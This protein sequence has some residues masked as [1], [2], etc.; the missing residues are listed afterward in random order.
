MH[1]E[2]PAL[3][4]VGL[5]RAAQ[6]DR[7]VGLAPSYLMATHWLSTVGRDG[8]EPRAIHFTVNNI[9]ALRL[10]PGHRAH[11]LGIDEVALEVRHLGVAQHLDQLGVVLPDGDPLALDC[12]TRRARAA[13]D[14]LHGQQHLG[15]PGRDR[16][17]LLGIDEVALEV[18]H[19]GVAQH[20]DQ[21]GV[22][23]GDVR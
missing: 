19:L 6:A 15:A 3:D 13:G 18:R 11:L 9:S 21:L 23:V 2:Q 5:G 20:L 7:H 16:A 8:R 4:Q 17:H 22:P 10:D 1:R 14:P 12:R